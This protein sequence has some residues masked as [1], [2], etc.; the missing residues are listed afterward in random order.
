MVRSL[1]AL[2]YRAM[3]LE[4]ETSGEREE[5]IDTVLDALLKAQATLLGE[6]VDFSGGYT[7]RWL[8]AR[9]FRHPVST[10]P[11]DPTDK[12]DMTDLGPV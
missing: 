1:D 6:Q 5:P 4:A 7:Y 8:K 3:E 2:I 11:L 12:P 10:H 9:G